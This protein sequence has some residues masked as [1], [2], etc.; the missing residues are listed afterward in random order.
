M[1]HPV[2]DTVSLPSASHPAS[3]PRDGAESRTVRRVLSPAG[4][5]RARE[6]SHLAGLSK[7]ARVHL[8]H[9]YVPDRQCCREKC[10]M[11]SAGPQAPPIAEATQERKLLA[12]ACRPWFGPAL[13]PMSLGTWWLISDSFSRPARGSSL[14]INVPLL[15]FP[16]RLA[17]FAFEDLA[18]T[19]QGQGSGN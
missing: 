11:L 3:T 17:Q 9:R 18:S 19:T 8:C 6:Q 16:V 12:V 15:T 7:A 1:V 2:Y 13:V 5:G 14:L 10:I 4:R